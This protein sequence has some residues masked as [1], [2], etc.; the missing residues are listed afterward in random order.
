[1]QYIN[2]R[3]ENNIYN[4]IIYLKYDILCKYKKK[5]QSIQ[6]HN[7]R[8]KDS[9]FIANCTKNYVN[10]SKHNQQYNLQILQQYD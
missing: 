7:N 9:S 1:M 2:I 6:N 10:I 8:N 4:I 5:L 3:L